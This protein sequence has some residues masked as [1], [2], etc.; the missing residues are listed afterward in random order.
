[1]GNMGNNVVVTE[2]PLVTDVEL[3]NT[4]ASLDGPGADM[5]EGN[6]GVDNEGT[7]INEGGC[8]NIRMG[9]LNVR[10][11]AEIGNFYDGDWQIARL[12]E[13]LAQRKR[14]D[15]DVLVFFRNESARA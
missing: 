2:D 8:V 11:L 5:N 6:N 13:Y 15:L 3:I 14:R 7:L 10:T 12:P 9:T 4:I 1:M